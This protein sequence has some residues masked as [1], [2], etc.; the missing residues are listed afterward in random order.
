MKKIFLTNIFWPFQ[1]VKNL[2]HNYN[3]KLVDGT[4]L[5]EDTFAPRVNFAWVK[6]LYRESIMN[7]WQFCPKGKF[8]NRVKKNRKKITKK[9]QKYKLKKNQK[10]NSTEGTD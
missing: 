4:K 2:K 5:H 6:T 7:E 9:Q 10:K 3:W 1:I 8:C